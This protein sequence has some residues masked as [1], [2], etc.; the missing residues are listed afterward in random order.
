MPH[1]PDDHPGPTKSPPAEPEGEPMVGKPASPPDE[2][3]NALGSTSNC[4]SFAAAARRKRRFVYS[5]VSAPL[6][7]AF[8]AAAPVVVVLRTHEMRLRFGID[9]AT[10]ASD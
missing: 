7:A 10:D 9:D 4:V 5:A 1:E 3:T 8:P 6:A 2:P